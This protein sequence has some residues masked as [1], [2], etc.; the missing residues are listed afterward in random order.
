MTLENLIGRGLVEEPEQPGEV[1]RLIAR[2]TTRL[3]DATTQ[4]ISAE[5]RFD[6]A[7]E[8]LLQLGLAALRSHNLRPDSRGGHHVLILQTLP[9]TAGIDH[10]TVRLLDQFRR[11][12][13][14][15]LYDG[16]FDP[17]DAE[18]EALLHAAKQLKQA[19]ETSLR[20]SRK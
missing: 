6:L 12:R 7:Y 17:T 1:D 16:S 3:N 13:A 19:V 15:G 2:A 5:S 14:I 10:D 9:R 11:Q 8:A 18:L 20:L 4:S